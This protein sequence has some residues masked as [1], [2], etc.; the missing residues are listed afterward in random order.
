MKGIDYLLTLTINDSD[1]L[2]CRDGTDELFV[3]VRN[4]IDM[5]KM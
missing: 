3:V 2:E 4:K 5:A 1:I